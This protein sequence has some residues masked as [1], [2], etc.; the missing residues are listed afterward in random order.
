MSDIF[1]DMQYEADKGQKVKSNEITGDRFQFHSLPK[2]FQDWHNNYYIIE[3]N[4]NID[5]N[6]IS[7][8]ILNGYMWETISDGTLYGISMFF[9]IMSAALK[10]ALTFSVPSVII[11]LL[12]FIPIL[13]YVAYHF[14]FYANIRAQI[15][16]PVTQASAN[17]TTYTFYS[18][19]GAV[20]FSLIL[21]SLFLL[22]LGQDILQ[23]LFQY[24]VQFN[25]EHGNDMGRV[26]ST[27]F[28]TLVWL[29][30]LIVDLIYNEGPWYSN[31]YFLIIVFSII[32]AVTILFFE[33]K[34]YQMHREVILNSLEEHEN[35][36]GYQIEV[37]KK[38]MDKWREEHGI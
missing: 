34:E 35:E 2:E 31:P 25:L 24:I 26:D 18:T 11:T 10:L 4:G 21:A 17:V 9:I 38:I 30:N 12:I 36:S 33:I 27:I 14:K 3:K 19:F 13:I 37:A 5:I 29:H 8:A 32:S 20:L 28:D 6:S 22:Y 15:I 16:G 7:K 1:D 23:V